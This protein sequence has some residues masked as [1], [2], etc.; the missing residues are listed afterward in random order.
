MTIEPPPP[1]ITLEQIY[2]SYGDNTVLRGVDLTVRQ[3]EA[4][5]LIGPSGG[6]KS[7]LLRCINFLERPEAGTLTFL[8]EPLCSQN[9]TNFSIAPEKQLRQAR[10]RMPMVFQQ[11][12][13]FSHRSVL[14][15]VMEGP[16]TVKKTPKSVAVCLARE[17]LDR[18]HMLQKQDHYPDQL[19]GGQKQRVAIARALAMEPPVI[20]FDEPTSA[21]DPELVSGVQTIISD[22]S[23]QGLTLLV[24]THDPAFVQSTAHKVCFCDDGHILESG[25]VSDIYTNPRTER[26]QKFILSSGS[27]MT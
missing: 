26:V 21:L 15:N 19:S 23:G 12:N 16:V 24:V 20:L 2:K 6:G 10:S 9:R 18:V 1:V 13:L 8:G 25:T 5:F 4:V 27:R 22:L 11:F 7:T 14:E 3:G 17:A